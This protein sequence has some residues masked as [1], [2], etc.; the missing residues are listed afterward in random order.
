[1]HKR[2]TALLGRVV[3]SPLVAAV[4][5]AGIWITGG[6]ITND[7]AVSMWLTLAWIALSALTCLVVALRSRRLRWAVLSAYGAAAA[8]AG[9]YLGPAVIGDR[10]VDERVAVAAPPPAASAGPT[11]QN[12][13]VAAGRFEPVRHGAHGN[14]TVIRLAH[15]GRVLT[16]TNF[17]VANGPDLRLYLVSGP[18]RTEGDVEDRIDLG[19]LKGN[20]GNQQYTIPTGADVGRYGTVVVWCRAFSVLFARAELSRRATVAPRGRRRP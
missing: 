8:A 18:A 2:R 15:G 12:A 16:L 19:A 14:A 5:L 17:A 4:V 6:L 20:E 9:L 1:M 13:W 11:R 10:V 7:F 3:V